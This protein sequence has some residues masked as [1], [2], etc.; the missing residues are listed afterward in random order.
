MRMCKMLRKR[1]WKTCACGSLEGLLVYLWLWLPWTPYIG[2]DL[3]VNP[4][5]K[6]AWNQR[7]TIMPHYL[8]IHTQSRMIHLHPWDNV[9]PVYFNVPVQSDFSGS[10]GVGQ[11]RARL[12]RSPSLYHIESDRKSPFLTEMKKTPK[13]S[14]LQAKRSW[15][16]S[17]HLSGIRNWDARGIFTWELVYLFLPPSHYLASI[18]GLQDSF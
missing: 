13:M 18:G 6:L 8:Q 10:K 5:K 11:G 1:N 12:T 14:F 15:R 16:T 3:I 4:V 7:W 17:L 9:F 2:M